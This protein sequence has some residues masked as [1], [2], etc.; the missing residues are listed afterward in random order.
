MRTIVIFGHTDTAQA[1]YQQVDA[2]LRKLAVRDVAVML[3][4]TVDDWVAK[5]ANDRG[6]EA[7]FCAPSEPTPGERSVNGSEFAHRH[8]LAA[9]WTELQART[10][11]AVR[12]FLG[13]GASA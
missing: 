1:V 10:L 4:F 7:W 11:I 9:T 13:Q 5:V 6:G 12:D 3:T 2:R 8:L